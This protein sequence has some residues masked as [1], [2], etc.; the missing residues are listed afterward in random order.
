[1]TTPELPRPPIPPF[2]A[3]TAATKVRMAEDAWNSRD[4]HR[5]SSGYAVENRM[6]IVRFLT[7]KWASEL[8]YR[9]L[10]ELWTCAG[11]RIA[12]RFASEYCDAGGHWCRSCGHE[13]WEFD[14]RGLLTQRHA[15]AD[16]VAIAADER[17]LLWRL[18]R[19]PDDHPGLTQLGL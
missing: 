19:R 18:G 6:Q 3:E 17:K 1:M 9:R 8:E 12:V 5:V 15:S 13:S 16:D 14:G 4:P 7:R 11:N 10:N 2:D